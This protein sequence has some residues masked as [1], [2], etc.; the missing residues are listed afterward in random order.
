MTVVAGRPEPA[1]LTSDGPAGGPTD[2]PVSGR[3][4][5]RTRDRRARVLLW[6]GAAAGA[7]VLV[8]LV[9]AL[10]TPRTTTGDLEPTSASPDGARAVAQILQRQGIGVE[11]VRT[12]RQVAERSSALRT[13]VVV[14]P[15]L[16]GPEQL[17]RVAATPGPLVLVDPDLPAL[18]RLAPFAEAAGVVEARGA[19]PACSQPSVTAAGSARAGGSLYR[20]SDDARQASAVLCYPAPGGSDR[21]SLVLGT[22][23]GR[24]VVVVGQA[25]VLRNSHLAD[26][27][28]TA[29]LALRL[30]GTRAGV[31]WYVPDPAELSTSDEAPTLSELVPRGVR[32][33][34]WQLLLVAVLAMVWR[35]RRLG[36][37]VTEPLPVVVRSTETQ[38]GRARLYR[39][40]KAYGRAAATLRTAALRRLAR[41]LDVPADASP[42]TVVALAAQAS[43]LAQTALTA[44]FLGPAPTDDRGLVR[45][46]DEIAAAESAVTTASS[47]PAR[48]PS[49]SG[50]VR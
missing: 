48:A 31:V 30:L 35:G 37:L 13:T 9:G 49:S 4:P 27:D 24:T 26:A 17:D 25:D 23:N 28:G 40:A 5:G 32:Y 39:R 38:E 8:A 45:L 33:V 43:G 7:L 15:E 1:D 22:E 36:R 11:T 16:L 14:H 44:T 18:E 21:G 20:L 19:E 12:S 34:A 41:R 50:G 47:R 46:A 10:T 2:G 29:A 6:G 42:A 3:S